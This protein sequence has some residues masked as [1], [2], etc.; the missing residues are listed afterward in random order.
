[1]VIYR[2]ETECGRGMYRGMGDYSIWSDE[3][4]NRHPLPYEDPELRKLYENAELDG[5]V[6]EIDKY[7]FG[8]ASIEQLQKWVHADDW[9]RYMCD[10][11]LV[12]SEYHLNDKDTYH[13]GV[14]QA[15]F[16]RHGKPKVMHNIRGYFNLGQ[17]P[18]DPFTGKKN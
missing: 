3:F 17:H 11:G 14:T 13:I 12:L 18:F 4:D 2:I 16:I 10:R 8:F 9:L 7:H 6:F 15:I 5:D 1:M